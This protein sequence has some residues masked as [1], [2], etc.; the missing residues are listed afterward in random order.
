MFGTSFMAVGGGMNGSIAGGVITGWSGVI[1]RMNGSRPGRGRNPG[2]GETGLR[3]GDSETGLNRGGDI[4][5]TGACMF[6]LSGTEHGW[7]VDS[8]SSMW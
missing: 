7:S 1:A 5:F 3:G 4:G 6:V 2:G 8:L